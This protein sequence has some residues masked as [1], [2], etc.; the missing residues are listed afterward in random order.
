M[1][2]LG[3]R[4][5]LRTTVKADKLRGLKIALIACI[6]TVVCV[7]ISTVCK[8]L[9]ETNDLAASLYGVF[10]GIVL[11]IFLQAMY[12]PFINSWSPN[13]PLGFILSV[14]PGLM[15]APVFYIMGLKDVRILKALGIELPKKPQK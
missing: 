13:N 14:L 8:G 1:F 3:N 15:A 2:Q 10:D 7:A 9:I 4:D 6:P 11:R 12:T 5:M